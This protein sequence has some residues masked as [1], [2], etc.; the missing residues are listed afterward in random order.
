MSADQGVSAAGNAGRPDPSQEARLAR[1]R[2]RSVFLCTPIARHPVRQY[3][4]SL[5]KTLVYLQQLGIRAYQQQVIGNSNLPRARNELAAAFLASGYDD[6]LWIDDDMGWQPNDVLRLL[7]SE[8]EVIGGV[9]C[10]KV[11]CPDTDPAKWC[12]RILAGPIQQD[13][14]GAIEVES[15]GTGFLKVAREVFVRMI[16]AHPDW[17]RRGWANMPEKT[18]AWYYRFF[19]FD[20]N[21]LD[22]IGED[23]GFCLEWRRLG[24]QVWIDPTIRLA[25]VGEHEYSGDLEAL[26]EAWPTTPESQNVTL[27]CAS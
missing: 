15:V 17:K 1:A 20:P 5:A 22:E 6:L 26:L 12:L 19:C 11:M 24:G 7:A 13:A 9:G 21:D 10:K 2:S 23:V 4:T 25:H 16:V 18:R 8:H 3:T 14:M 27:A